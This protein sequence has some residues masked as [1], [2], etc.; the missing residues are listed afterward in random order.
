MKESDQMKIY[1]NDSA[2]SVQHQ[3]FQFLKIEWFLKFFK[4]EFL[5][6]L[7][8]TNGIQLGVVLVL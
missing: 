1:K 4:Y 7:P 8:N 6:L 3:S 5:E 2:R